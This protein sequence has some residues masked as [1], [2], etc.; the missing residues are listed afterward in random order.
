MTVGPVYQW[1]YI[2]YKLALE[3]GTYSEGDYLSAPLW[4]YTEV[5]EQYFFYIWVKSATGSS[6]SVVSFLEMT[7]D[8]VNTLPDEDITWAEVPGSRTSELTAPGSASHN[9]QMPT[10]ETYVRVHTIITGTV[11]CRVIVGAM[12]VLEN[13]PDSP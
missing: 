9:M 4:P 13:P 6:P 3:I 12:P 10:I 2:N 5:W 8:D 7:S 11:E 1:S